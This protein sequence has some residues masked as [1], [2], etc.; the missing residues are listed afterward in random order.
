MKQSNLTVI[1][2]TCALAFT[3]FGL[4]ACGGSAASSTASS[5][6][7]SSSSVQQESSSSSSTESTSESTEASTSTAAMSESDI[8]A[9]FQQMLTGMVDFYS[10]SSEAGEQVY[11]AGGTPDTNAVIAFIEPSSSQLASFIGPATVS[12]DGRL[13][14]TDS[15]S[16][17]SITFSVVGNSDDTVT[18]NMG[19][20]YGTAT[21]SPCPSDD[22]LEA[23]TQAY[24]TAM[25]AGNVQVEEASSSSSTG[26]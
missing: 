25:E 23:L 19:S 5:S 16:K 15:S 11:F 8:R 4:S 2:L 20:A 14:I 24:L 12:D 18:F 21:L 10:G 6:T 9:A 1:L 13:T 26:E 22:I 17:N 7:E 3:A